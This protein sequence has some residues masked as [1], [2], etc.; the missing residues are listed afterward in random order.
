MLAN[1]HTY[2]KA[3]TYNHSHTNIQTDTCALTVAAA[4]QR[5][6]RV[7]AFRTPSCHEEAFGG[8]N[9]LAML[10]TCAASLFAANIG[11]PATH[12]AT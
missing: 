4:G 11:L 9:T 2:T 7:A 12:A 5:I 3:K 8:P 1:M 6:P 10:T